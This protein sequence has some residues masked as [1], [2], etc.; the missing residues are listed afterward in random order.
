MSLPTHLIIFF[1]DSVNSIVPIKKGDILPQTHVRQN[2]NSMFIT[3]LNEKEV[4]DIIISCSKK[5][6]SGNDD[7]PCYLLKEVAEH[8]T[9]PLT[10]LLNLSLLNGYF[11]DELKTA[12]VV[13]IFKKDD[14]C[15]IKNYRPIALLSVFSKIFERAFHNKL[16]SF[17]E[18]QKLMSTRQFGFT[19]GRSTQEAIL[20]FYEKILDNLNSNLKSCGIFYDLSRA[21]DTIHHE[22]LLN[23]LEAYGI[24]GPSLKWLKSY[25]F[26]RYQLVRI[27]AINSRTIYSEKVQVNTGVPQG[28]VLG[29]LLFI[30]FVND[31]FKAFSNTFLTLFAD[32]TSAILTANNLINLSKDA[33]VC[34][35]NMSDW[36]KQ[37]GLV[38]NVDKTNMMTFSPINKKIDYSLL[39]KTNGKSLQQLSEVKFLGVLL[40]SNLS[41]D[42]H[43][44]SL[45]KTLATK[46]YM[47][48]QLRE[49]V[50]LETLKIFYYA[51]VYSVVSYGLMCWGNSTGASKIFI[52]QKRILRN[53]LG[54]PYGTSC[55]A[56]FKEQGILTIYNM[57]IYQC[58]CHIRKNITSYIKCKEVHT[59]N[60]RNANDFLI[61]SYR[62]SQVGKGP[63][64]TSIKLYNH[65]PSRFKHQSSL[66]QFK[67]KVKT[68]L[69]ENC[70]YSLN[71]YFLYSE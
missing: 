48:I 52:L 19:K 14:P 62:L 69:K 70:F 43:I 5:K 27:N 56:H 18:T 12:V 42:S 33:N 57:Y 20:S 58:L 34:C 30:I 71:E 67:S 32:D 54:L 23:K 55:R 63:L 25:L 59:H 2:F 11:P 37:N 24:R 15:N 36:C 51:S 1:I 21:F 60:T 50:T 13:P 47:I 35:Q 44:N 53:M 22:I 26:N 3:E 61:P 40:D 4:F 28:S 10:Y 65:L 16:I 29:P 68:F 31:I 64:I 39:V 66:N 49:S 17:L 41:W 6:S 46:N 45:S 9:V 38:L 7:I 8:I